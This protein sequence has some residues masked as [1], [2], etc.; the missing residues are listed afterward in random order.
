MNVKK[1][2]QNIAEIIEKSRSYS[3]RVIDSYMNIFTNDGWI[4][5]VKDGYVY[6]V[7]TE[8]SVLYEVN[9]PLN[10]L[11][12]TYGLDVFIDGDLVYAHLFETS[13]EVLEFI[14]EINKNLKE[15]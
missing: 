6:A 9:L 3:A 1:E 15:E 10:D 12:G 14:K 11:L 7:K 13:K 5:G 4:T 2:A 8:N